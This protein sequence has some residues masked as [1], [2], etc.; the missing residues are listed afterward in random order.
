VNGSPDPG[1]GVGGRVSTNFTPS[2]DEPEGGVVLQADG[3]IVAAGYAGYRFALARYEVDGTP[4][5]SFGSGGK[6]TTNFTGDADLAKALAVDADG[7]IVAAGDIG[8]FHRRFALARY[9]S[10]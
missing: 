2:A 7:R 4:D 5:M 6:V 9:L 3:K 10:D 8:N 1:F